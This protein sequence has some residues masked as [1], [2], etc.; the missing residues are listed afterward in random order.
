MGDRQ[1]S[2]SI[3]S[4]LRGFVRLVSVPYGLATEPSSQNQ[5]PVILSLSPRKLRFVA[6]GCTGYRELARRTK[7]LQLKF[8]AAKC[9]GGFEMLP[10]PP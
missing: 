1:G 4:R 9:R 7:K 10:Q 2:D 6:D 3:G 5:V 8:C